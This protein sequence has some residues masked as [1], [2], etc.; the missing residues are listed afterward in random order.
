MQLELKTEML[1]HEVD[2]QIWRLPRRKHSKEIVF[3]LRKFAIKIERIVDVELLAWPEPDMCEDDCNLDCNRDYRD[4]RGA[5]WTDATRVLA[6]EESLLERLK[7]ADDLA[8]ALD[9]ISDELY[10]DDEGL[11]GL[12]IGVASAVIA[13]SAAGCIPSTSC[14]GGCFGDHHHESYPLVSFYAKPAW[15]PNLLAAAEEA[16]IG[17]INEDSGSILVYA[18]NIS[19]MML[20]AINLIARSKEFSKLNT[21]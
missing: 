10:E 7:T 14:N 21:E 6:L 18:S 13:L 9:S 8:A 19:S 11:W 3:M 16:K 17:L 1:P 15:V 12:D 5:S 20:F 2:V 4:M